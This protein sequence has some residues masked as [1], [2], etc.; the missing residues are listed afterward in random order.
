MYEIGDDVALRAAFGPA[1]YDLGSK[2]SD[3]AMITADLGGSVQSG[4]FK[5]T[6]PER[7]INCGV[8]ESDM[9]GIS[10][11]FA[12]SGFTPFAVTFG[13]FVGRALDHIR[14]SV[15]HNKL[16]V[17]IVGSHGGI[18]N[19][20]DGPSAHAV[21]DIGFMRSIPG[22]SIIAPSCPNQLPAVLDAIYAYPSPVYLRLYREPL[23]VFTQPD[24]SFQ[25]GTAI[26][27][28]NGSD[29]TVL[30]YGPH[31]GFCLEW[32]E[33]LADRFSIDLIEVP[34]IE[35]LDRSTILESVT[36]TGR[37]VT[38]EDH[39][40][41]GGLASAAAELLVSEKPTPLE[42]V[43]LNQYARSGAYYELRDY[44]GLGR[45]GFESAVTRVMKR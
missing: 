45:E 30:V 42:V 26:R 16:K 17:V 41:H 19:G 3:V 23:P 6:F 31:T 38:V 44:V 24:E 36:R 20:K 29:V 32:R 8:A 4:R 43:A 15:M 12:A 10:A 40:M 1:L 2:Y 27:R 9:I 33:E 18:S 21:E 35:P 7:Y 28:A 11:G 25:I 34:T 13:S 14:Q 37:V 39:Y 5:E 22:M